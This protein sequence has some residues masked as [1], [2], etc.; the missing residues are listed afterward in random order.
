MAKVYIVE[1]DSE[2]IWASLDEEKAM[3]FFTNTHKAYKED[4]RMKYVKE[5]IDELP[6]IVSG[7]IEYRF[8]DCIDSGNRT[9]EFTYQTAELF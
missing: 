4:P 6:S 5:E 7:K 2:I 9:H 3:D 8:F 1:M